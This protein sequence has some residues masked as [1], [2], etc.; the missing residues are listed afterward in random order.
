MSEE[1]ESNIQLPENIQHLNLS[2]LFM[3][4][5]DL[6]YLNLDQPDQFV[7][8]AESSSESSS[9][10]EDIQVR[11]RTQTRTIRRKRLIPCPDIG[12]SEEADYIKLSCLICQTNQIQTVNFPCMHACFCLQCAKPSLERF[13]SCPVCR[14]KYQHIA[15]L[16]LAADAQSSKKQKTT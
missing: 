2:N 16:Y 3:S 14:I 7:R 5:L 1:K 4:D 6:A 15:R 13:K 9:T 8:Y 12:E 10:S 11:S